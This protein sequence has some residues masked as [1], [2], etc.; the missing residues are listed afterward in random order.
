[1]PVFPGISLS[2]SKVARALRFTY[3]MFSELEGIL[4]NLLWLGW[5]ISVVEEKQWSELGHYMEDNFLNV[6][7]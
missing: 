2:E 7:K 1:M 4:S 6:G 3:L 5:V